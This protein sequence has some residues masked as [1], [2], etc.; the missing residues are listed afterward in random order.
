MNI[1][2]VGAGLAGARTAETLR[3]EG[4]DGRIVLV[5]DEPFGPYERPALSKEFLAGARDEESL[6][7]RP[8]SFWHSRHVELRLR[9]RVTEIDWPSH[10]AC[11]SRGGAL[12]FD[13]LVLATGARPR[14][15][16]L[17][18]PAGVHELRTLADAQRLREELVCGARLVV[19]G[20]GFVGAEVAS[21]ARSLGVEVTIVEA[22]HAPV[23]RMLGRAS[24]CC[25][26]SAGGRTTSTSG[27]GRA[28]GTSAPTRPAGF[29]PS[30]SRTARRCAR[31][32]SSSVWASSRPS[33]CC[34][35][36]P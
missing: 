5:G 36:V 10:V 27:S 29:R 24:A 35:R 18:L 7:L 2:I 13:E 25:W 33:N 21:T 20:G 11:T 26:P 32:S 34:R 30:C 1:A 19:I 12:H 8:L 9:T 3:A 4:Y 16:P 14:R 6:L 22:A 17:E 31:T 28:S 15:L 23:A